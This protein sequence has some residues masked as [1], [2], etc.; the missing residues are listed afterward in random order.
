MLLGELVIGFEDW[1]IVPCGIAAEHLAPLAQ[2]GTVPT[3]HAAFIYALARIGNNPR[4]VDAYHLAVTL[5]FG[6]CPHWR[7]ER[8][9]IVVGSLKLHAVSL[10]TSGEIIRNHRRQEHQA[11]L[12]PTLVEGSLGGIHNS[13]YA[14][15][16]KVNRSAVNHDIHFA[17]D[18][19]PRFQGIVNA[20]EIT[21]I[22]YT[23]VA[24][25][26]RH[27]ELF[28]SGAPLNRH[29]R[30]KYDKLGAFGISLH[31]VKHILHGVLLN[32]TSAYRREGMSH[33]G[34]QQSEVFVYLGSS[35]HRGAR[36]A[37]DYP[38]FDGNC[39]WYALDIVTLGFVH[40]SEEL[41]GIRREALYVSAL[42]FGIECVEGKRRLA[43]AADSGYH[44]Q[45]VAGYLQVNILQVIHPRPFYLN[46]ISHSSL[47]N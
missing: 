26:Q 25:E 45:F 33:A 27:L 8:E 23:R 6:T 30:C 34:E 36:V 24:L 46:I 38:L 4:R 14:I 35:S 44:H 5:T 1:E 11:T 19:L 41:S 29:K 43:R 15:S 21:F 12:S 31:A 42:S 32:L 17:G 13:R 10:E 3:S 18:I 40:T 20:H 2:L 9:H 47:L 39:G 22:I 28:S 7:V 16:G 37:A